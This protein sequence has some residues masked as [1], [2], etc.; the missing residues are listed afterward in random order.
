MYKKVAKIEKKKTKKTKNKTKKPKVLFKLYRC[1][2]LQ[3]YKSTTLIRFMNFI[4]I[5]ISKQVTIKPHKTL[6]IKNQIQNSK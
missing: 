4:N 6:N 5:E 2:R 1:S 3:D